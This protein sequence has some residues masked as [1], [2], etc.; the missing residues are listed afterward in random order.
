MA[1]ISLKI[2]DRTLR[3][4]QAQLRIRIAHRKSQ[5]YV[6]TQV[7]IEPQYF[8][9][10]IYQPIKSKAARWKEK[11][12]QVAKQVRKFE[13]II[14][15]LSR[16]GL[17]DEMTA[18]GIKEYVLGKKKAQSGAISFTQYL[19]EYGEKRAAEKTRQTYTYTLQVLGAF[20]QAS[21]RKSQLLFTEINYKFLRE[22]E[23]WMSKTGKGVSTRGIV[24]RN[25][26]AA[27]N[28]A[29]KCGVVKFDT[30]PFRM[31][32]IKNKGLGEIAYLSRENMHALLGLQDLSPALER[33][34]DIFLISFYLCG[35]NL[36]D[37]YT[38]PKPKGTE[39]VFVRNKIAHREP[40]P[41]HI[42]IEPELAALVEKYAGEK[43]LFNFAEEFPQFATFQ[44]NLRRRFEIL[45]R[46]IGGAHITLAIA[47][48]TWATL[49]CKCGV[50]EYVISKSLGHTDNDVTTR[51]YIE[52]DWD[53][54]A[55]ANRKVIDY[56]A[57]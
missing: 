10:D 18:T 22:F 17:L 52:Y 2:D 9:G 6:G 48:H 56:V 11:T 34:R 38:L 36:S 45:S 5:A 40:K 1:T 21:S 33:S 25:I 54:T 39:I 12:E 13:E 20:C 23:E 24:L 43:Y 3:A 46:M 14:F 28:E 49:A 44:R 15:D 16:S 42:R 26:R 7:Y 30:Y 19:T 31:F 32:S 29:M 35:M 53:R 37:I 27:Y 55:A 47:R 41:T 57:E 8:T 50:E 4:G 51:H